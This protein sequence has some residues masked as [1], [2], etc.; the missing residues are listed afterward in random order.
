MLF[1][2]SLNN[3]VKEQ[4]MEIFDAIA[5]CPREN[6]YESTDTSKILHAIFP[7]FFVMWDHKIRMSVVGK[8]KD[9]ECYAY[10]FLPK[11]KEEAIEC[12][13]SYTYE[14]ISGSNMQTACEELTKRAH[15][16][17]LPKLI[18]EFNY[19]RYTKGYS[20]EKISNETF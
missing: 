9:G 1:E 18:D 16:R 5:N 11:M 7:N 13:K 8:E 19:V 12:L 14:N 20:L 4:I 15:Y 10:K 17:T 6:R 2:D 3:E